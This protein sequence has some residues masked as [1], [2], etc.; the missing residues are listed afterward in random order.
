MGDFLV[1]GDYF[2]GYLHNLEKVLSRSKETNLVLNWEKCHF[3]VLEGI[4]LGHKISHEGIEV[5]RKRL[6]TLPLRHPQR[7]LGASWVMWVSIGDL[8]KT[9]P[10][11]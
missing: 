2:E 5:D 11:F 6:K 10:K 4:V 9:S 1:F 8:S 3:M 7:T